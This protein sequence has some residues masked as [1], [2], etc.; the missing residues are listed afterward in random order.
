[1]EVVVVSVVI[2][3]PGE[4]LVIESQDSVVMTEAAIAEAVDSEVA[5]TAVDSVIV[6]QVLEVVDSEVVNVEATGEE[7][8]ADTTTEEVI[9][10]APDPETSTFK[11]PT[12]DGINTVYNRWPPP[13]TGFSISFRL[14]CIK[15]NEAWDGM[16]E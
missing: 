14:S 4:A 3:R 16:Y 11:R 5:V 9:V 1:M 12:D 15:E 7:T 2:A 8:E 13:G 6:N 10:V